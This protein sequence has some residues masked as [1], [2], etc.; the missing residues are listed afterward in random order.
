MDE[1]LFIVACLSELGNLIDSQ[2]GIL[3]YDDGTF[4]S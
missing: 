4:Y 2:F 1:G 3:L